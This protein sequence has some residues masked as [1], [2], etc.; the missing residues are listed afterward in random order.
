M[1]E[2]KQ[3]M[4]RLASG[5]T[6]SMVVVS[7]ATIGLIFRDINNMYDEIIEDLDEFKV[8][9]NDAWSQMQA[10]QIQMAEV[11]ARE[12]D[13]QAEREEEAAEGATRKKAAAAEVGAREA[14]EAMP[15]Q[16]GHLGRAALPRAPPAHQGLPDSQERLDNP[17]VPD[18][19]EGPEMPE[20]LEHHAPAAELALLVLVVRLD[21]Q[22]QPEKLAHPDPMDNQDSL[23][24]G[25]A[26]HNLVRQARLEI[27]DRP[28]LLEVL[29]LPA[30]PETLAVAL[31]EEAEEVEE[32]DKL[33]LAA[34]GL[35]CRLAVQALG[36]AAPDFVVNTV[37]VVVEVAEVAEVLREA[38]N[39][40]DSPDQKDLRAHR[41]VRVSLDSPAKVAVQLLP[42]LLDPVGL[43]DRLGLLAA[44][45]R[46]AK[47][48]KAERQAAMAN[49]GGATSGGGGGAEVPPSTGG[50]TE[51]G[52]GGSSGGGGTTGGGG[53]G[54]SYFGQS[55]ALQLKAAARTAR[56]MKQPAKAHAATVANGGEM[57][58][59][60]GGAGMMMAPQQP[61]MGMKQ[62]KTQA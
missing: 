58:V 26:E 23:A 45:D 4:I 55:M 21:R 3:L 62:A 1:S 25:E 35:R 27:L 60:R 40:L 24:V 34:A 52:A 6:A 8:L 16:G 51:G 10:V 9:A 14:A 56:G 18:S 31:V 46:L 61:T 13:T 42:A 19:Q 44:M 28:D 49:S 33:A 5:I 57:A 37:L 48:D 30:R 2:A 15:R 54:G 36:T 38:G 47:T 50:A 59:N 22:V 11:G 7:L 41:E 17:E 29:D 43:P 12:A 39:V 32:K 20:H 53:T